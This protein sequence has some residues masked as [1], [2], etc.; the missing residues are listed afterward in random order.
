MNAALENSSSS[1]TTTESRLRRWLPHV[2]ALAV[3]GA[4]LAIAIVGL[5]YLS[6]FHAYRIESD[7]MAPTIAKGDKIFSDQGYY[8]HHPIADGDLIVF[9]HNDFILVKRVTA[10]AG[11]TVAITNGAVLRNGLALNEPYIQ[12]SGPPL[13]NADT[14]PAQV[15]PAGEL[16]V[17]GDN[18]DH[19]LD[20]R[21][22]DE[23]G[24]VKTS[25]VI[26]KATVVYWSE[27]GQIGRRS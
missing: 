4:V 24:V 22:P 21:L 27:H 17:T 8:A 1:A 15:V 14:V 5:I 2:V 16:F 23:F 25:D 6:R 7:S 13:T 11:E 18:R 19:S 26:G 3:L 20:S 12:H 10:M 9:R